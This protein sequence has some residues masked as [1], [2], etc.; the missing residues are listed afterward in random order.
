M[1][2]SVLLSPERCWRLGPAALQAARAQEI[3]KSFQSSFLGTAQPAYPHDRAV[4]KVLKPGVPSPR[5]PQAPSG[6]SSCIYTAD[7]KENSD[8]RTGLS[9]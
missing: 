5:S 4:L 3:A 6:Y 7:V 8:P 2:C 9:F 1:L